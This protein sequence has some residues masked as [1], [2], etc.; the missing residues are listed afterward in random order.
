[1]YSPH[2]LI[3][4]VLPI[5]FVSMTTS[6]DAQPSPRPQP[7]TAATVKIPKV[8]AG[9]PRV[10]VRPAD[11]PALRKKVESDEFRARWLDVQ[12]AVDNPKFGPFASAFVYL[13]T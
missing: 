12:A 6:A 11:L 9:H 5:L 4:T 13:I 10:Y 3:A 1:M 7:T 8:P 2:P